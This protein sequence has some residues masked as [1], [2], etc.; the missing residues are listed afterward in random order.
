MLLTTRHYIFYVDV[1]STIHFST[2]ADACHPVRNTSPLSIN[3]TLA[4]G[5]NLVSGF[6]QKLAQKRQRAVED[7]I[8]TLLP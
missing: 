2:L 8:N 4:G 3:K 5:K 6:L 7:Y 1:N